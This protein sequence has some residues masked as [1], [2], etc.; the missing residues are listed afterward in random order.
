MLNAEQ[1]TAL[2]EWKRRNPQLDVLDAH[3]VAD[4]EIVIDVVREPANFPKRIDATFTVR[5]G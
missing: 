4:D 3:A 5:Q 2:E 1:S